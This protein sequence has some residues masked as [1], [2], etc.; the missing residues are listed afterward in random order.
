MAAYSSIPVQSHMS[1]ST[2]SYL[3]FLLLLVAVFQTSSAYEEKSDYD[4]AEMTPYELQVK[5]FRTEPIRFG[6]R[7]PREPIRFGKRAMTNSYAPH[8][9]PG[10]PAFYGTYNH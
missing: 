10:F 3:F 7:G 6:K 4:M 5:R 9:L 2:L 8:R 1:S